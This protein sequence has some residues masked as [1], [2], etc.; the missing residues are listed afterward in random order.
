MV[1]AWS[2]WGSLPL[3]GEVQGARWTLATDD[4]RLTIAVSNNQLVIQHLRAPDSPHDWIATGAPIPLLSK[5]WLG[6]REALTQW[7]F[8]STRAETAAP[9]HSHSFSPMRIRHSPAVD[10]ARPARSRSH[11]A[12]AGTRQHFRPACDRVAPRTASH[13]PGCVRAGGAG[14]LVKRGGS[15]ASTQGR[16][17]R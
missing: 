2:R 4:T 9:A 3:A 1:T 15:N 12:L 11:R 7:T 8:L 10:L 13:S 5:V 14:L 17:V 16:H 6:G